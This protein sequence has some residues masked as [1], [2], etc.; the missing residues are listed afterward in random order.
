MTA[1]EEVWLNYKRKNISAVD[2]KWLGT[3]GEYSID[4][5]PLHHFVTV[6]SE[7]RLVCSFKH[8]SH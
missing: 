4:Y 5:L 2:G 3:L 8:D 6:E 1:L 7:H